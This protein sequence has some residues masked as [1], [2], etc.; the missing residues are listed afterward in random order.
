VIETAASP[1][2]NYV[3]VK[4]V[5]VLHFSASAGRF[6]PSVK[7]LLLAQIQIGMFLITGSRLHASPSSART[8]TSFSAAITTGTSTYSTVAAEHLTYNPHYGKAK[9]KKKGWEHK[10]TKLW[11]ELHLD[12]RVSVCEKRRLIQTDWCSFV[13]SQRA[14]GFGHADTL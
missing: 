4:V 13:V 5:V 9:G 6:S 10:E 12:S 1:G 11:S 3:A 7:L 14:K 2:N 8:V